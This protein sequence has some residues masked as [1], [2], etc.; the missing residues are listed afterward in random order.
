VPHKRCPGLAPHR[1]ARLIDSN[2]RYCPEH[3]AANSRVRRAARPYTRGEQQR[4]AGVVR[5]HVEGHG[6]LCPGWERPAH[7]VPPGAL[8][9]D[10]PIA[11][12]AGGDESQELQVLCVSCNSAKGKGTPA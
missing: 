6:W 3:E 2:Q 10:H 7:E 1:C 8:T 12:A 4:R 11:V 9:A 5:A